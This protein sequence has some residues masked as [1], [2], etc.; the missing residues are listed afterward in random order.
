ML[1]GFHGAVLATLVD[2][3]GVVLA[4]S[5]IHV[6][7]VDSH[8]W[9]TANRT[10]IWTYQFNP[11][12]AELAA[13]IG[14]V[15]AW[16]PDWITGLERLIEVGTVLWD[17]VK[18]YSQTASPT[19]G[20]PEIPEL[21]TGEGGSDIVAN[22]IVA[23][24]PWNEYAQSKLLQVSSTPA[25]IYADAPAT[26]TV[27]ASDNQTGAPVHGTVQISQRKVGSTDQPIT[28]TFHTKWRLTHSIRGQ[29]HDPDPPEWV[30]D[31]YPEPVV[32][33]DG[34]PP[35]ELNMEI[36]PGTDPPIKR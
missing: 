1:F 28:Y 10:D 30:Y 7:G 24:S 14:I 31:P 29:E 22:W 17:V 21:G 36:V 25:L 2:D 26:F 6:Y 12:D 34:Y 8:L 3:K 9:G 18:E 33:A 5:D 11:S 20:G 27:H 35:A 4:K 32:Y 19:D 15:H 13:Q 23:G 16:K